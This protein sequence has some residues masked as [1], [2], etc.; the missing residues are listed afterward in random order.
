MLQLEQD[1]PVVE[2]A[3]GGF[4]KSGGEYFAVLRTAST[5]NARS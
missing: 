1:F 2:R 5:W 3:L 4:G